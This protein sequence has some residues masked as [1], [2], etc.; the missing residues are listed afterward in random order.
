M[1]SFIPSVSLRTA[2]VAALLT[3][4]GLFGCSV[5]G[6]EVS[7]GRTADAIN[8]DRCHPTN[9]GCSGVAAKSLEPQVGEMGTCAVG[10]ELAPTGYP[11]PAL[12]NGYRDMIVG[13]GASAASP[14]GTFWYLTVGYPVVPTGGLPM[15]LFLFQ[16][17]QDGQELGHAELP[18]S[19][20]YSVQSSLVV[21][22]EGTVTVALNDGTIRF[23][24]YVSGAKLLAVSGNLMYLPN[25]LVA[26]DSSTHYVVAGDSPSFENQGILSRI[27]IDGALERSNN[28]VPDLNGGSG[29][30]TVTSHLEAGYSLLA[31]RPGTEGFYRILRYDRELAPV[32]ALQLPSPM[33][34]LARPAMVSDSQGRLVVAELFGDSRPSAVGLFG[35]DAGGERLFYFEFST[36]QEPANL[37]MTAAREAPI[38]W[39]NIDALDVTKSNSPAVDAGHAATRANY[40]VKI[41][42][43]GATCQAH[44]YPA[45]DANSKND[46]LV[47][48]E[49]A[50]FLLTDR[51]LVRFD[52]VAGE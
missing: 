4:P 34:P 6:D 30:M 32:W 26:A 19:G 3:V 15:H 25:Q 29:L 20:S 23:H 37:L 2:T 38:V 28:Q 21:D 35:F 46:V 50:V 40:L 36:A 5:D 7:V 31:K 47:N 27:R 22:A 13:H 51:S 52:E 12:P 14:D 16:I 43:A 17:G 48:P 44:S 41:D 18:I 10:S 24:R 11:L 33:L 1:N 49:G 9:L 42:A 39:V 45:L 8:L